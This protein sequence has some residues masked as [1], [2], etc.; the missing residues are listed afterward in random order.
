M[1]GIQFLTGGFLYFASKISGLL[2]DVCGKNGLSNPS[3]LL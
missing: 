1:I 3:P 2:V